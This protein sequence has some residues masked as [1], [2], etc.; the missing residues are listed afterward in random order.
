MKFKIP[1]RIQ[2][3]GF[4]H[5]LPPR[6]HSATR[7]HSRYAN[8]WK[9]TEYGREHSLKKY[10]A[11]LHNKL[12]EDPHFLDHLM[13]F[14]N[15]ACFCSILNPCHVDILIEHLRGQ[16]ECGFKPPFLQEEEKQRSLEEFLEEKE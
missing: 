9:V 11:W 12:D 8:P 3:K 6:T 13:N 5:K 2:R 16:C 7:P 10:R 14:E 1:R 15:I 4:F